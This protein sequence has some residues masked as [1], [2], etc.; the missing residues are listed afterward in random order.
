MKGPLASAF[1]M[2]LCVSAA[3]VAQESITGT[4]KGNIE[5][6]T[7]RGPTRWGVTMV[8]SS[9]EDGKVKGTGMF[10]EGPCR[11][12][13][14]IVGSVKGDVVGVISPA[15]GGTSG[16]C[17]FGFKGK[18]EGNRLVGN[19]GKYEIEFRK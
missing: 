1:A 12:D 3:A 14:P 19:M 13:Y 15:K 4:Y 10:H 5:V 11:G 7:N 18:I 17:T 9:V 6:N 16:D 2:V 8:I